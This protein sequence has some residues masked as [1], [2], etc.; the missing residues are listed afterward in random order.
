MKWLISPLFFLLV[1]CN[2]VKAQ[3]PDWVSFEQRKS[4]YPA[5]EFFKGFSLKDVGKSDKLGESLE[6]VKENAISNLSNS[7]QVT[8]ESVS[9][10]NTLEVND[11]L[12]QEFKENIASFSRVDLAGINAQ[13]YHD[14][15]KDRVYAFAYV[16][17]QD[18][19]DYYLEQVILKK[20][21]IASKIE[22]ADDFASSGRRDK[23]LKSYF[24][25][26]PLFTEI[27]EA[28][29]MIILLKASSEA[30][31]EVR[32]YQVK[33]ERAINN[34]YQSDLVSLKEVSG[35]I[36]EA[37]YMQTG[38]I[39]GKVRLTTFTY[40]D[41]RMGSQFSRRLHNQ[42][43]QALIQTGGFNI[44]SNNISFNGGVEQPEF[45]LNGTY[46]EEK[47]RI[48]VLANLRK[49]QDG[50]TTASADG[51]LPKL[52]LDE[53][54]VS[55]KPE[56]FT[57]AH[58]NM[59]QFR[60]DEIVD[61]NMNLEVWTSKGNESPIFLESDTL[62]FYVRLS[63]P[64]YVRIINHFAD[65]SR[66]LLVDNMYLG[67]DKVNKV[68]EIPQQ[69]QC[70]PPFGAEVLQVNAQTDAFKPLK[71]SSKYGYQFIDDDLSTILKTTRGFK[72]IKNEDLKAEKRIVVTTMSR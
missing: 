65:G 40:E 20:N 5:E 17:K 53:N 67:A 57:E 50:S 41:T 52:W 66:V 35:L 18:L 71:T 43:E 56:N 55:W 45:L 2:F 3:K 10:L 69:F 12:K 48:K 39:E 33:V 62:G 30:L 26:K 8:V 21:E 28:Q 6:R 63:H 51:Y 70:A 1:I 68:V 44:E 47:G 15:R 31:N 11:E 59:M 13:T 25:C 24:E 4:L 22:M 64:A 54:H 37:L 19:A 60:K 7:V 23:A 27:K 42:L 38:E 61:G 29:S 34:L 16:K 32:D 58:E 46:W 14:K 49:M 72:P 9:T 36:A